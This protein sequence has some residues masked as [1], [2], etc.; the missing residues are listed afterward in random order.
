MAETD[1][2]LNSPEQAREDVMHDD[3]LP[4]KS[5]QGVSIYELVNTTPVEL[6][7]LNAS[8]DKIGSKSYTI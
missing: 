4:G 6:E 5:I 3:V 7:F 2:D 1:D 8:F